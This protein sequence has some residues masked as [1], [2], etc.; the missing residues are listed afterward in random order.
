MHAWTGKIHSH[1]KN[2][3]KSVTVISDSVQA[4]NKELVKLHNQRQHTQATDTQESRIISVLLLIKPPVA[5]TSQ[6]LKYSFLI[7]FTK[8]KYR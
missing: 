3:D 5:L 2:C 8:T 7:K 6:D 1:Q 4:S